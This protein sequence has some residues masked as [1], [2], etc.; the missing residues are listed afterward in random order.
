M[1]LLDSLKG[2]ITV[3]SSAVMPKNWKEFLRVDGNK[4]ELF[5][6]LPEDAACR[7][8]DY[9]KELY[10]TCGSYV[11]RSPTG[12]DV[13]NLA[14]CSHEEADTRL[15]LHVADTV[16]KGHKRVGIQTRWHRCIGTSCEFI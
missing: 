9:G 12:L 1:Y 16:M 2:T 5:V 3:Y 4:T 15:I 7:A 11:L 8:Q 10:S 14:P 6:F 13:S